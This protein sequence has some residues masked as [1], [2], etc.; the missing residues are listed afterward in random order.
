ME[1]CTKKVTLGGKEL[2]LEGNCLKTGDK[3]PNFTLADNDLN[4]KTLSDFNQKTIILSTVPSLDTPTCD[5]ETKT[6]NNKAAELSDDIIILTVSKD[7]PFAQKRWCAARGV[8]KV[9]TL[10]DY[11]GSDFSKNYGVLIKELNLLTRAIY[12]IDKKGIIRYK[13]FVEEVSKEPNYEEVISSAKKIVE[14]EA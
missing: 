13:Q 11:K 8:D 7:L 3:A 5:L 9:I 2:T 4:P 14:Q 1:T 10:S 6:F 12:I